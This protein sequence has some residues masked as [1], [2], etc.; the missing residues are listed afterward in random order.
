MKQLETTLLSKSAIRIASQH[1]WMSDV[2]ICCEWGV[3]NGVFV[4][5]L[6]RVSNCG[7]LVK[8]VEVQEPIK[9]AMLTRSNDVGLSSHYY[10]YRML[11]PS[12]VCWSL[13]L[14]WN[15]FKC[16]YSESSAFDLSEY[17]VNRRKYLLKHDWLQLPTRFPHLHLWWLDKLPKT[18]DSRVLCLK[19]FVP[20]YDIIVYQHTVIGLTI[21]NAT[22]S[23][24]SKISRLNHHNYEFSSVLVSI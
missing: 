3:E 4:Q 21:H 18:I 6:T 9:Q 22:Q 17:A 5:S 12:S 15:E 2:I 8:T 11:Y 13:F 19:H 1:C 24:L 7:T 16:P 14:F 10:R 20:K 23:Q